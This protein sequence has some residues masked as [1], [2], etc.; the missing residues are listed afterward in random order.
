MAVN[1]FGEISR[2]DLNTSNFLTLPKANNLFVNESGD[3]MEGS[4]NMKDNKIINVAEPTELRDVSTKSYVD[5]AIK[6]ERQSINVQFLDNVGLIR[7]DKLPPI[8]Y[9]Q[10]FYTLVIGDSEGD[11]FKVSKHQIPL[12][13]DRT[14]TLDVSTPKYPKLTKQMIHFQITPLLDTKNYHDE[15]FMNI[16]RY[17]ITYTGL[18]VYILSARSMGSKWG[19][20]L[21]AY[22]TVTINFNT[23]PI[24]SAS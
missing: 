15:I 8:T 19:L 24:I 6:G 12:D 22:L 1:I 18:D 4:L 23:I 21:K 3:D 2:G 9:F 16:Q 17:D 11:V 7:S 13:Y 5:N 14:T 10:H 20:Y